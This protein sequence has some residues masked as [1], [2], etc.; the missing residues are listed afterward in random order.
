MSKGF[1]AKRSVCLS[2]QSREFNYDAWKSARKTLLIDFIVFH[3]CNMFLLC[4][5]FS[6]CSGIKMRQYTAC[7]G[8]FPFHSSLSSKINVIYRSH[9]HQSISFDLFSPWEECCKTIQETVM[10]VC[11]QRSSLVL[12]HLTR[13]NWKW[14][15]I[16]QHHTSPPNHC[17][18]QLNAVNH[19]Y[20]WE[21]DQTCWPS[22]T[23]K[24][25]SW[26]RELYAT[27]YATVH[28]L[29]LLLRWDKSSM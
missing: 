16:A 17:L 5:C 26:L 18:F 2:T 8:S 28:D 14:P 3:F 9:H 25:R 1:L 4:C 19:E 6:K 11:I 15:P 7:Y 27:C 24:V 20:S 23:G 29:P 21:Q 13:I 22:G 10:A 12:W